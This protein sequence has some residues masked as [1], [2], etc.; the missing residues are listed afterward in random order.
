[1]VGGRDLRLPTGPL[2]TGKVQETESILYLSEMKNCNVCKT[3][4]SGLPG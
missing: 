4:D 1:M 2:S 3:V